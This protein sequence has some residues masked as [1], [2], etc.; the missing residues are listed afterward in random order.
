MRLPL[1][2]IKEIVDITVSPSELADRLTMAGLEVS[3]IETKGDG[4]E[5]CQV[6]SVI[7][8]DSHPNADRLKLCS[9]DIGDEQLQV[10]CGAPNVE[11]GQRIAFAKSGAELFNTRSG[12]KE[13]L[14]SAVIRGIAS[15]G[16]IC[17]ELELGIGDDHSGILVLPDD[18]P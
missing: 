8:V 15:N 5:Y 17:S 14:K 18:A 1:S 11:A 12:K 16:M 10:V 7:S 3:A 4:W 13:I 6:G 2:W 9:V